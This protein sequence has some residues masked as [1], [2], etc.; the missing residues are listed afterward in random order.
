MAGESDDLDKLFESVADGESVDWDALERAAPDDDA[1]AL[2]RQLRLIAE[3]A[4]V[5]RSQVDEVSS[6]EDAALTAP[7]GAGVVPI[8]T[9]QRRRVL[10]ELSTTPGGG[11]PGNIPPA[12]SPPAPDY[13]VWGHLL[14]VRK[15]GEGSYGE[16]FHAHDTWLDHPVALKL[17][18][19]E[20][21]SRVQP[22]DLLHEARKLARVRHDNVVRVHGADRH[23]GRVGFWM[24]FIDG[25]TLAVRVSK[26]R[27]SAGEASSVGLEV[28][29]ALAAVHRVNIIHRD[30]KAQ[31]VMRAHDGGGIIL[32]DFGAGEFQGDTLNSRPQ[33]T[34]LYMAPELFESSVASVRTDIYAAGVLLFHLVTNT[35][36]VSG[37][38]MQELREAH[39]RGERRRLRDERPDLPD[40]FITIVERAID[41]NPARRYA[42]AGEMEAKLAGEPITRPEPVPPRPD[43]LPPGPNFLDYAKRGIAALA[44]LAAATVVF[45]FFAARAFQII[46][47][48][49]PDF[50]LAFGGVLYVG[51]QAMIPFI[52]YGTFGAAVLAG[53][54]GLRLLLRPFISARLKGLV[55]FA[56]AWDPVVTAAAILLISAASWV[57]VN[58]VVF[59]D[60]FGALYTLMD[61]PMTSAD[62]S[63]LGPAGHDMHLNHFYVSVYLSMLL[64][65]AVWRWFPALE[66]R[67]TS[68][69][70]VRALKWGVVAIAF[71]FLAFAVLPRRITWERYPVVE[72]DN[73]SGVVIGNAGDEVLVYTPEEPG[74]PRRRMRQD[75]PG[76]RKTAETR[77][78]FDR[79]RRTQ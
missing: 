52:V 21:E 62:L 57:V 6:A 25:E 50:S 15:I 56:N 63:I 40:S 17:L 7:L 73:R 37:G 72:F 13:G 65:V 79:E 68:P 59:A 47:R 4:E 76:F 12:G 58:N 2:I 5:H 64:A 18:K 54:A 61:D 70:A 27:L 14:L 75:A 20:A 36:P 29:R 48:V 19:L 23:N 67:T 49:D 35:F 9:S 71:T 8:Q 51:L 33:G 77:F 24:D 46:L 44:G 53:I 78:L 43:P 3:V 26:G 22:S 69:S 11:P 16:V 60:L 32:M 41:P 45:G 28:C 34:P 31:N 66:R 39:A 74:R 42:S 38:S 55:S 10:P 1:R 30:V